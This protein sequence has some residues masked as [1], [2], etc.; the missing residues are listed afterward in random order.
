MKIA[1]SIFKMFESK[2]E[3]A[4]W[5]CSVETAPPEISQN[6][7][8]KHPHQSL[9]LKQSQ[10]IKACNFIK[11]E[12]PAQ[13]SSRKSCKTPKNTP[14]TGHL[15]WLPSNRCWEESMWSHYNNKVFQNKF[16]QTNMF[17]GLS[18]S[19]FVSYFLNNNANAIITQRQTMVGRNRHQEVFH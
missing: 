18:H 5:R 8:E 2:T 15:R 17:I 6:P 3:A 1:K 11:K 7:H 13:A 12:T 16:K 14:S 10:R 9:P 19:Q 4:F